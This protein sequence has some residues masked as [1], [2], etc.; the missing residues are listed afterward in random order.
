MLLNLPSVTSIRP[1]RRRCPHRRELHD[2]SPRGRDDGC[3]RARRA[4]SLRSTP[5]PRTSRQTGS[6]PAALLAA[7][8]HWNQIKSQIQTDI[9]PRGA[10]Q[11]D[12]SGI[13]RRIRAAT[14]I[15]SGRTTSVRPK[16]SR[17]S[18]QILPACRSHGHWGMDSTIGQTAVIM[19]FMTFNG[20]EPE[21]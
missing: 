2:R 3:H 5:S 20:A 16:S 18:S 7:N 11:G 6:S 13:A 10:M 21:C 15:A 8:A 14:L 17:G 12:F 4:T 9:A 1:A 19:R